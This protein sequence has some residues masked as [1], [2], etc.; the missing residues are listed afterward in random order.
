L[1][2][3]ANAATMDVAGD[4]I[5]GSSFGLSSLVNQ[6]VVFPTPLCAGYLVER[7]GILTAFWAAGIFMLAGAATLVPL[8]L[9]KGNRK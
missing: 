8:R 5:Q 4:N 7:Y 3:I 6:V 2:N 9:Y 1:I